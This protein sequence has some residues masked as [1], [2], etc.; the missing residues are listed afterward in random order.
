MQHGVEEAVLMQPDQL[1]EGGRVTLQRSINKGGL[2]AHTR[3]TAPRFAHSQF[4]LA[5]R[6][7]RC[8]MLVPPLV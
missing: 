5:V 8:Q 2:V 6:V 7:V 4:H 1:A 3:S